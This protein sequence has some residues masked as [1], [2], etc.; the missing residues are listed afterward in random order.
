MLVASPAQARAPIPLVVGGLLT[1]ALLGVA[2]GASPRLTL[3]LV[4]GVAVVASVLR[5]FTTGVALFIVLQYLT[6]TF[7]L[8]EGTILKLLGAVLVASWVLARVGRQTSIS[9]WRAAPLVTGSLTAF[10]LWG[11]VSIEWAPS[12][13]D[14]VT[15]LARIGLNV[16][17]V[18]MIVASIRSQR[19]AK[20][21][22]FSLAIGAVLSATASIA[23]GSSGGDRLEGAGG[24]PNDF[25][26]VLGQGVVLTI[27]IVNGVIR[28]R[29]LR[30]GF[31]LAAPLLAYALL[32]TLSRGGMIALTSA[33]IAFVAFSGHWRRHA[34]LMTVVMVAAAGVWYAT[35]A[36]PAARERVASIAGQGSSASD[37]GSGRTDIWQ[38]GWR[39]F[40]AE[41]VRGSGLG[42]YTNVT[43]RFLLAEPGLLRRTDLIIVDPK[44]AHNMYLHLLVE[45]GVI[46]LLLF[47]GGLLAGV[48]M[49]VRAAGRF[50]RSGHVELELLTRTAVAASIGVLTADFFL[51]GQYTRTLWL[52][53]GL[54]CGL[55]ALARRL[56]LAATPR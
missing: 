32:T 27:G 20:A 19:D 55:G 2:V 3:A 48:G 42:N 9:V 21:I 5:D 18:A 44:V 15:A 33:V 28:R 17:L 16:L 41:P 4:L 25:A 34:I 37:G 23:L 49:A 6:P 14:V 31:A 22:A 54:C 39:A 24:D 51:S 38:V 43:P 12:H 53:L 40:K 36:S 13:G 10:L 56:E 45:T 30:L 46:G 29:A 1:A 35:I 8:A 7:G 26:V 47:A 52:G 50:R 11:A